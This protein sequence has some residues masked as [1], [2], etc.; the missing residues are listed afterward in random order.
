MSEKLGIVAAA[1]VA[2]ARKIDVFQAETAL[3]H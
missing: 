2:A 3:K 1:A